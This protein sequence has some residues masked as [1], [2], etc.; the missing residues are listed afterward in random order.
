MDM[1]SS[2][3][4]QAR[5]YVI[6][7]IGT[8]HDGSLGNAKKLMELAK[9]SGAECVKFQLHIADFETTRDAPMP[10]Y[11]RQENRYEYF[12]RTSFDIEQWSQL[13]DFAKDLEIDFLVSPF[14][15]EALDLLRQLGMRRFKVPSGELSN[16]M[17]LEDIAIDFDHVF[18]STG[19]SNYKEITWAMSH[20]REQLDKVT[21]MQ[22]TS[23]YPCPT[24]QVGINVISEF[25]NR[26]SCRV[27]FSDH[28]RT[29]AAAILGMSF[30]S[31]VFEK[32]LTFSR[33]MYGSDAWNA[34][35]PDEFA[36]YCQELDYAYEI[37][38]SPIDKDR[39]E[40]TSQ[41][42]LIFE[43]GVYARV[44][45]VDG[46]EVARENLILLKPNEGI[47]ASEYSKI[48]GRV[49]K[50][51]VSAYSPLKWSDFK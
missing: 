13:V 6:A 36:R 26:Y 22:C 5:P 29:T 31:V 44:D 28:T 42:K 2:K 19:M 3:S 11:F 32:H 46:H 8:V 38:S 1:S 34:F 15:T 48:V 35:E 40:I 37:L 7:E 12:M 39:Q 9:E 33:K 20:F 24:N 41:S 10:P 51:S 17:L 49:L 21:I 4:I 25:L 27:G 23:L 50:R 45:M 43:K 30:G 16:K 47:S 14:S 18:I